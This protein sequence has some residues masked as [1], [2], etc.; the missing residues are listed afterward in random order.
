[1]PL[2]EPTAASSAAATESGTRYAWY[3]VGVLLLLNVSSFI[4]RQVMALMV[5]PIKADS[6]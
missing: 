4:D 5:T 1:M 6:G 3:V 2:P